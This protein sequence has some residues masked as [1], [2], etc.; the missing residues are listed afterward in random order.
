VKTGIG[1]LSSGA[2]WAREAGTVMN[3][4]TELYRSVLELAPDAMIIIDGAGRIVF[5][6]RQ[7]T[8]LFGYEVE[9]LSSCSIEALLP[10]R[11]RA[12][13]R[14]HRERYA[15]GGR[16]RPMGSGL[17]LFALRKDGTEFPVEIS[18]SPIRDG[19]RDLVAAAIRDTTERRRVEA[20]LVAARAAADQANQAKSR[21][22]ATAS[23][24]LRQP[25]QTVALLNGV[26]RRL[27]TSADALDA[28]SHQAQSIAAMSRLL[29]TL[30]DISKLESGAVKPEIADFRVAAL[31]EELRR[32]F[33]TLAESKGL[34]LVVESCNDI[35]R[36]DPSLVAQIM[37]NLMANAIKYTRD[38]WVRLRCLHEEACVRLEVLDTGVGIPA[39]Q[40]THIFEEFYQVGVSPNTSREGYGLGLSIVSRLVRLLDLK[41]DVRSEPGKGSAFALELPATAAAAQPDPFTRKAAEPAD[42]ARRVHIL[43]VEDD[44]NVRDATRMLLR[45]E[46]Y[47]VT[48]ASGLEEA[49]RVMREAT[50]APN[51][52]IADY[53][54][55]GGE[56][57]MQV[58]AAAREICGPD[59]KVIL[60][61]GDTSSAARTLAEEG[62][63]R[64][65]SKPVNTDDLMALIRE[66]TAP[67]PD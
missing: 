1:D 58:V 30:L 62:D 12:A 38:G 56:T 47:R 46:G 35:V 16:M 24:D 40:V 9:E 52:L 59:L 28:L 5:A 7:V 13:H 64:I 18:L 51:L 41:L 53:H 2:G 61:T 14:V 33:A 20:D 57:G 17:A 42:A 48:A 23:H 25:L 50:D 15:A 54:L 32:E 22:L 10:E 11:F 3:L 66:L 60:M 31:F 27:A 29:N 36:S 49:V 44:P 8:A 37:Q 4:S 43:L 6:N 55:A 21:F 67:S 45:V 63:L 19:A 34:E 26:L 65:V 39:D